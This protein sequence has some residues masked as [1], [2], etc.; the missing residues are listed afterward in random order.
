MTQP[1]DQ[2]GCPFHEQAN[3]RADWELYLDCRR[4]FGGYE[5]TVERLETMP[6]WGDEDEDER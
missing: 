2:T 4:I 6:A 5:V 3:C 1:C